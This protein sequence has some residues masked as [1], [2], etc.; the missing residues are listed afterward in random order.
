MIAADDSPDLVLYEWLSFP[1]GMS[2]SMYE[3]L[4]EYFD[5]DTELWSG[6]KKT[7]EDFEYKGKHYYYPFRALST[8][9]SARLLIAVP[10]G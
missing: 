6:M 4:D 3:P 1:G 5:I 2:K 10:S 9:G 7:I 8:L